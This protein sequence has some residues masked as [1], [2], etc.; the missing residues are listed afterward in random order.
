MPKS[1]SAFTGAAVSALLLASAAGAA[2]AATFISGGSLVIS[3]TTYSDTG[4][5]AALNPSS[6]VPQ[7][8]GANA[9]QSVVPVSG[10]A[11]ATVF[12]NASVDGSFGVTSG[13]TLQDLN[14]STGKAL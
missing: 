5:V 1:S 3:T 12:N 14:V 9:G 11:F 2:D 4:A 13:I 10:G 6:S 7:L 8:P